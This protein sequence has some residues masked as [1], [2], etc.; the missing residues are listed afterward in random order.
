MINEN[1]I[2]RKDDKK[3]EKNVDVP[4]HFPFLQ[5]ETLIK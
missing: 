1:N 5:S 2:V 3:T 4:S